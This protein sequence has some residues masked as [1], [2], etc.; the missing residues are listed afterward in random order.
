M[1]SFGKK[2]KESAL[3]AFYVFQGR[4]LDRE[5]LGQYAAAAGKTVAAHGGEIML[6]GGLVSVLAGEDHNLVGVIGFPTVDAAKK[7]YDSRDYQ[8]LIETRD[9]GAAFRISLYQT[10]E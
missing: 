2:K 5:K 7:W 8:A 4:V 9:A 10:I 6:R 1:F 3:K